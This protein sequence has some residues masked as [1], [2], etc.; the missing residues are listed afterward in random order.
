LRAYEDVTAGV[1]IAREDRG[2]RQLVAYVVTDKKLTS[3]ELRTFLNHKLPDYMV[4]TSFVFLERLPLT[5]NGKLDRN[6]LPAPDHLQTAG[7]F[8]A[9]RTDVEKLLAQIWSD[10]LGIERVGV[11]DNF[12]DL[13]GDSIL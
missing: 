7:A 4:P 10:V 3:A 11:H 6:A 12:F 13:G 8:I 5:L 9:P 1:V 2:A